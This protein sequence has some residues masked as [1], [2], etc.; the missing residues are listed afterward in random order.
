MLKLLLYPSTSVIAGTSFRPAA[1][2]AAAKRPTS[3]LTLPLKA[4]AVSLLPQFTIS[5][6]Q[7]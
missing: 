6:S 2:F 7:W 4:D 1:S 3:V 5:G